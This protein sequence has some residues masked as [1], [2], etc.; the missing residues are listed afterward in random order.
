VINGYL[1]SDKSPNPSS[2][3]DTLT[4]REREVLKLV[5]EGNPNKFIADPKKLSQPERQ[6][7]RKT[8]FQ[9]D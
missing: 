2:A 8:S 4:Q 3:W 5:G 6:D 1:G 7:C 9:P